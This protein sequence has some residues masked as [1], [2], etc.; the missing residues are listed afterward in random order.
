ML[1]KSTN[2]TTDLKQSLPGG[3]KYNETPDGFLPILING[4]KV[5]AGFLERLFAGFIDFLIAIPFLYLFSYLQAINIFIAIIAIIINASFFSIY[6]VFFNLK[7]GGTLGKLA[8]GIRIT[9]PNG[10]KIG[11]KEAILRSVVDIIYALLFGCFQLYAISQVNIDIYLVAGH[12]E[13]SRLLA[14]HS[15]KF[16]KYASFI[17][18]VWYW[19]EMVILLS[20]KRK[21]ALHDFI[22]GTVVIQK[23][24]SKWNSTKPNDI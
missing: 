15:P 2:S 18:N 6:T 13:K 9:K 19:S 20:N 3:F 5:Y 4:K 1:P 14:E 11:F 21:R 17:S 22:A 24:Y 23:E 12:I 10:D 8:A 7:Y 16:S